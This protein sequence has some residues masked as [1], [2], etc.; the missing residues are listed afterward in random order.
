MLHCLRNQSSTLVISTCCHERAALILEASS[1]IRA[2]HE[3]P[4]KKF[5]APDEVD[6]ANYEVS[7]IFCYKKS[8]NLIF[9]S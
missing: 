4:V 9:F 5:A 8:T 7:I 3:R 2:C 6:L 1:V